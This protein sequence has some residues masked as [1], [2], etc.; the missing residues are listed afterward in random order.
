MNHDKQ[1]ECILTG[2]LWFGLA[3]GIGGLLLDPHGAVPGL[4]KIMTHQDLL[5]TDY[6]ELAGLGAALLNVSLMLLATVGLLILSGDKC[7]G[8]TL[9]ELGLM[10]G[11]AFFGKNLANSWP[12][13]LGTWIFARVH[14]EPFHR[15]IAV[16][17]LTTSL[18]PLVSWMMFGSEFASLPMGMAVGILLGYV[19]PDLSAYTYK[20]LNGVSLYNAG[21][22]CGLLATL[23][24]SILAALGD[25]PDTVLIWSSRYSVQIGAALAIGSAALILSAFLTGEPARSVW[26][27]WLRILCCSGRSPCDW[28][29][30]FGLGAVLFNTGVN[31]ILGIAYILIIG[32][33]FSGPVVGGILTLMGFAGGGK[34]VR[35]CL[36]VMTG[37]A[38]GCLLMRTSPAVES[39]QIA[40]LF[41]T[42]LAPVSGSFGI[43]A[44]VLAGAL[45]SAVVRQTGG[46]VAGMNLY[47]NGFSGG[48][49]AMVLYPLLT[50]I[51]HRRPSLRLQNIDYIDTLE[52][53]IPSDDDE[54][55]PDDREPVPAK[56]SA[57][58]A[59]SAEP[60]SSPGDSQN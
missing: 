32:G 37:V 20:V 50:A 60:A 34:H 5:I 57:V 45:H 19:M 17:L 13:V 29:R 36:P 16:A 51:N 23:A 2:S 46:P 7:H 21:F 48:L 47:N 9:A 49:V 55:L 8:F 40:G 31:G 58:E 11:F 54:G 12:I 14:R 22:A 30:D 27:G 41:G 33:Q 1:N 56:A 53:E 24:V 43:F 35:N 18:A 52:G 15:Y 38:V 6:I 28:L 42:T 10:A 3:L 26:D 44:G 4:I 59:P 25:R 39:L